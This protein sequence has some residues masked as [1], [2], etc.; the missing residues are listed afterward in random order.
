MSEIYQRAIK[1]EYDS[2]VNQIKILTQRQADLQ[3]KC[4]HPNTSKIHGS[5]GNYETSDYWID[6]MCRDCGNVKRQYTV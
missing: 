1:L 2:I 4:A 3:A 5:N 6:H